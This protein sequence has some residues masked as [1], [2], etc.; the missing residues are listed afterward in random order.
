MNDRRVTSQECK[1][2]LTQL[3][4]NFY[5]ISKVAMNKHYEEEYFV[6]NINRSF[7]VKFFTT[8]RQLR[9]VI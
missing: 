7:L 1:A 2:F 6:H 9:V 8:I 3:S 5:E 4:L